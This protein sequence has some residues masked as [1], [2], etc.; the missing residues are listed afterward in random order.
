MK[1]KTF[2]LYI[3]FAV[4]SVFSQQW[5]NYYDF[6]GTNTNITQLQ[7]LNTNTGWVTTKAGNTLKIWKTNNKGANWS[8]IKTFNQY[9]FVGSASSYLTFVNENTG[10]FAYVGMPSKKWT[11][12]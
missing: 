7:F 8:D 1:T 10:Y 5:G 9:S 11:K 4:S 2:I 3:F 6:P 12:N